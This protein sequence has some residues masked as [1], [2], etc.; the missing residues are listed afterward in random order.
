MKIY[1]QIPNIS[2]TVYQ[3][4]RVPNDPSPFRQI[5]LSVSFHPCPLRHL[6]IYVFHLGNDS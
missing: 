3:F 6:S 2:D 4:E 1:T 5:T